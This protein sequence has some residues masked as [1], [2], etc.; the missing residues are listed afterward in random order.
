VRILAAIVHSDSEVTFSMLDMDSELNQILGGWAES[1]PVLDTAQPIAAY[2]ATTAAD[3]PL[4]P[5][6][7]SITGLWPTG[8]IRGTAVIVGR[9][10]ADGM[11]T[12]LPLESAALIATMAQT[13]QET[14]RELAL[15]E[16]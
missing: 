3:K 12:A 6:A 7:S 15:R 10:D 5:V 16:P 9:P 1:C 13:L 4:N 2:C 11:D 14:R 8:C